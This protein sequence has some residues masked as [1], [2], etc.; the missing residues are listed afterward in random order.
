[1]LFTDRSLWTMAHGVVLGGAALMALAAAM[2]AL[3]VMRAPNPSDSA[4]D[5]QSRSLTALMVFIGVVLWLAVFVGTYV[6]FPPYRATPPD[7]VVDLSQY[8]RSLLLA[9]PDTAWLHAFA[10]ESKEH[11]PWIASMLA[12]A[13]AF[14]SLR[15]RSMLLRDA[16]LRNMAMTLL[17]V[18]FVLVS[19]VG[20]MGIFIDKVA[21]LQ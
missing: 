12:T 3:G 5:N 15:Y 17:A 10:M 21:P 6:I 4:I 20:L 2:F 11:M 14:V 16:E 19:F 9:N 7:G 18:S 1:M 8:P 13:V